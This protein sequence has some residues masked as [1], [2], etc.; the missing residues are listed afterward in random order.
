MEDPL[1]GPKLY[2]GVSKKSAGY[3]LMSTMGWKEGE[4]LVRHG[5][6]N[7]R[8]MIVLDLAVWSL[9]LKV[10]IT[11]GPAAAASTGPPPLSQSRHIIG[12]HILLGS[13]YAAASSR[14]SFFKWAK[15]YSTAGGN[16]RRAFTNSQHC[17]LAGSRRKLQANCPCLSAS[18]TP[19]VHLTPRLQINTQ[20]L[21]CCSQGAQKQGIAEHVKVRK[22][23]DALGVG[24]AEKAQ[25]SR[26][27]TTG[28]FHYESVL[29]GLKEISAKKRGKAS[30][31]GS[32][33]EAAEASSSDDQSS[34]DRKSSR[35]KKRAADEKGTKGAKAAQLSAVKD[36]KGSKGGKAVA[37]AAAKGSSAAAPK[38][39]KRKKATEPSNSSSSSSSES[40]DNSD[41]SSSSGASSSGSESADSVPEA[42]RRKKFATHVGRYQKREHAKMVNNY[43][44]SDLAAILGATAA[45]AAPPAAVAS[46]AA[47]TGQPPAAAA[48]AAAKGSKSGGEKPKLKVILVPDLMPL[49]AAEGAPDDSQADV[50]APKRWWFNYFVRSGRN[51]AANRELKA[52]TLDARTNKINA[53]GFS[54][55]DQETL[56][57]QTHHN[58]T[59]GKQGLGIADA[60]KK[61]GRHFLKD[62][63]TC[64]ETL[65]DTEWL[66]IRESSA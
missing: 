46:P 45:P 26:D 12:A 4:G 19:K 53:H 42:S 27:W 61:V 24:A 1:L 2:Q 13:T 43:S 50:D 55:N 34:D 60:P 36:G 58:A 40:D 31:S 37:A 11:S 8:N 23:F 65:Q 20:S 47:V 66:D 18:L 32:S 52:L 35:G 57:H 25:H 9:C 44:S 28:M 3:K 5:P 38:P 39:S 56:Y 16:A 49:R 6:D 29:S 14:S 59:H 63:L 33:E 64:I 21:Q 10:S 54:E 22:K 51:G 62:C 17:R 41:D 48:D 7:G 30:D 15:G